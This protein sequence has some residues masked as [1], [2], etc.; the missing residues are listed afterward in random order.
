[1]GEDICRPCGGSGKESACNVG[2]LGSIPGSGKS[3]GEGNGNPLQ[4]SCQEN[5]MDSGAWQAIYSPQGCKESDT[6]EHSTA[7]TY[8]GYRAYIQ[9]IQRTHTASIA[10]T[11]T[12]KTSN[13]IFKMK[14][15]TGQTFFQRKYSNSQEVHEKVLNI[16]SHRESK[17]KMWI[18]V[19]QNANVKKTG[20]K[21]NVGE[22]VEEREP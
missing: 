21:A 11:S 3:P 5:P 9:N 13:R 19:C 14:R 20:K 7:T 4:Y 8:S 1:M 2:D 12:V 10:R 18:T 16:T 22:N 17:P 6:T 15:R